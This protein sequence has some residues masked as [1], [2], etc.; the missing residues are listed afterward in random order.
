MIRNSIKALSRALC[1]FLSSLL[2]FPV[3]LSGGADVFV[4]AHAAGAEL[5]ESG[6]SETLSVLSFETKVNEATDQVETTLLLKNNGNEPVS[7]LRK[8]PVLSTGF[9]KGSLSVIGSEGIL[10]TAEEEVYLTVAPSKTLTLSYRYLTKTPLIHTRV[11]GMDLRTLV[12][13]DTGRIGRFLLSVTLREEDV[14]LVKKIVPVNFSLDRTTVSVELLNVRPS[15]LLDRFY[16][17]K[18][19]YRD[20]KS[21]REESPNSAQ[22]FILDHY[23]EW[24]R[25][26]LG[27][28]I[29]FSN[30]GTLLKVL[31][32]PVSSAENDETSYLQQQLLYSGNDV[33]PA[34][35]MY[36]SM[37]DGMLPFYGTKPL[38]PL[39]RE[40]MRQKFYPEDVSVFA[41]A[42]TSEPAVRD[43][44]RYSYASQVTGKP[45][46]NVLLSEEAVV[47]TRP[48]GFRSVALNPE[49][50]MYRIAEIGLGQSYD[51]ETLADYLK[52]IGAKAFV[53]QMILDNRDGSLN[54]G[55]CLY[56]GTVY[57]VADRGNLSSEVFS[58]LLPFPL[59]KALVF[60]RQDEVLSELPIPAFTHYVA[61]VMP[62]R[63]MLPLYPGCLGLN[64]G[65]EFYE[66][67]A[68][69]GAGQALLQ[70][71]KAAA[72]AFREGLLAEIASVSEEPLTEVP[73]REYGE[74]ASLRVLECVLNVQ[75]ASSLVRTELTVKNDGAE[76]LLACIALPT[77]EN[78]I[79]KDSFSVSDAG[80]GTPIA[81]GKVYLSIRSGGLATVS[82]SYRTAESLVNAGAISIDLKK[83]NL[84]SA[85]RIGHFSA[86]I[87]LTPESIPLVDG[88]SPV[89]YTFDGTRVGVELWDFCPSALLGRFS[90]SK[91]TWRNL[92]GR[93][94]TEPNETGLELMRRAKKW[95]RDGLPEDPYADMP[96]VTE[97]DAADA[98]TYHRIVGHI[99]F[100]EAYQNGSLTDADYSSY[101]PLLPFL[102][103]NLLTESRDGEP[104]MIVA[105]EL[106]PEA[107]LK[108]VPLFGIHYSESADDSGAWRSE[109]EYPRVPELALLKSGLDAPYVDPARFNVRP[110]VITDR[111]QYSVAELQDYLRA[112]GADLFIRTKLLDDRDGQ[113]AA[114]R[115]EASEGIPVSYRNGFLSAPADAP[116]S[117]DD[118]RQVFGDEGV[119]VFDES[120]STLSLLGIPA[121]TQYYG[122]VVNFE[123]KAVVDASW[124]RFETSGWLVGA[125]ATIFQYEDV[126]SLPD[127]KR[128]AGKQAAE[129]EARENSVLKELERTGE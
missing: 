75:E 121:Y 83:V 53:R 114:Y 4:T 11:I 111:G 66:K 80:G 17:E 104:A 92:L 89:N 123:E 78:R 30:L 79:R 102:S 23:Q 88:V 56:T 69:S 110:S 43:Q 25:N 6:S 122:V 15:T 120:E 129:R 31:Q 50:S 19:T 118:L 16:L 115:N 22:Q 99:A 126:L 36:L 10:R 34:I 20:L 127:A 51:A 46:D 65:V 38:P 62:D 57:S 74:V 47:T 5:T 7:L 41:V 32:F 117:S 60:T 91:N 24:F 52:A 3:L 33:Y 81:G 18:E 106:A 27:T 82:Y 26:G 40:I 39:I 100:M 107:A 86:A 96:A 76:D 77:L 98:M 61:F 37:K 128:L 84:A 54:I 58:E 29:Q 113:W 44:L 116:F 90:L 64:Y 125:Y 87:E 59:A 93:R 70:P 119:I 1:L 109:T 21:Q 12:F 49:K 35:L 8:L 14:P 101:F 94:E 105:V 13:G 95:L 67:V 112:V 2:L 9:R 124:F 45:M 85:S 28:G 73:F 68:E 108:G 55:D 71:V 72:S 42:Y 103:R 48:D 97:R 63:L